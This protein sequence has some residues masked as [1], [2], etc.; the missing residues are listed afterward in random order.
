MDEINEIILKEETAY[1]KN[2]IY[3]RHL[4]YRLQQ[5]LNFLSKLYE[6]FKIVP[7]L[8]SS[9][10]VHSMILDW[11]NRYNIKKR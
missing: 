3:N 5:L 8:S 7:V 9:D 1:D 10:V 6:K 2:D 11:L 4:I